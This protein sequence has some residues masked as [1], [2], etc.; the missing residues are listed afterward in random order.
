MQKQELQ[1]CIFG[2]EQEKINIGRIHEK[3]ICNAE[4]SHSERYD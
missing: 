4:V 3:I 1:R 2:P